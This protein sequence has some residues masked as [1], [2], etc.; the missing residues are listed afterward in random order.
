MMVG[1][2]QYFMST[3]SMWRTRRLNGRKCAESTK[4]MVP[5]LAC[6]FV[7]VIN[8]WSRTAGNNII[9]RAGNIEA[10]YFPLRKNN[11][12]NN[13]I[14]TSV[15]KIMKLMPFFSHSGPNKVYISLASLLDE[16]IQKLEIK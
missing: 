11:K 15:K 7:L 12:E 8:T 5:T 1:G 9:T 13:V 14:I 3:K 2:S 16:I 10:H 6:S 4:R